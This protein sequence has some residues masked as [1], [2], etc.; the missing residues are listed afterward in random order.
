MFMGVHV[1][2][3]GGGNTQCHDAPDQESGTRAPAP[4]T[5]GLVAYNT[6]TVFWCILESHHHAAVPRG[7]LR[8]SWMFLYVST[9]AVLLWTSL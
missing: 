9:S 8:I 4:Q 2:V 6:L 7:N 5:C 3:E 1:D